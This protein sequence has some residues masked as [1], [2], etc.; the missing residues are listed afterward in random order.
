[1][2]RGWLGRGTAAAVACVVGLVT[3][4]GSAGSGTTTFGRPVGSDGGDAAPEDPSKVFG[5]TP[6][7]TV[8][9][10]DFEAC[11]MA[12][13]EGS[14]APLDVLLLLDASGSMQDGTAT[15][16]SKWASVVSA[17]TSFVR[18]PESAGIG[19]GVQFLPYRSPSVPANC[20][21]DLQCGAYGPCDR[22]ACETAPADFATG[23]QSSLECSGGAQ[24]VQSGYCTGDPTKICTTVGSPCGGALGDCVASRYTCRELDSCKDADYA[25]LP[26]QVAALPGAA[27]G[28]VAGMAA[29]QPF[30]ET[31]TASAL[32]GAYQAAGVVHQA[33]LDHKVVLV[34]ATDALPTRC[35]PQDIPGVASI[36]QGARASSTVDTFVMGVFAPGDVDS[37]QGLDALAVAGGT[38]KAIIIR[39]DTN[40]TQSFLEALA[41]IGVVSSDCDFD[42][43]VA[44]GVPDYRAVNVEVTLSDGRKGV[45]GYAGSAAQCDGTTGGWYY[46]VDP[47][48]GTPHTVHLCAASCA[49]V[50]R[51]PGAH[52]GV[53]VG[54]QTVLLK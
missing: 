34:F 12:R 1:M 48:Q 21:D 7:G 36:V 19:V 28:V 45:V 47:G 35:T 5:P 6:P 38:D 9:V 25:A 24:C 31:P 50:R 17:V 29:R 14:L 43:Q 32:R 54:C 27:D 23:C 39:T 52:V 18:A 51:D 40:V 15:R 53:I 44:G 20:T 49:P 41:R 4:C 2:K 10:G 46:D 37:P 22:K 8:R 26:I 3:A 33:H 30:G 11:A 16:A 13:G 42:L